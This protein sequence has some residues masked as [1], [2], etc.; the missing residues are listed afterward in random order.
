MA[1]VLV[2]LKLRLL[3]N[4]LRGSVI[5]K[6]G[7]ALGCLYALVLGAVAFTVLVTLRGRPGD[8]SVVAEVGGVALAVG[9]AG[10][11]LLGFGSDET[12]DPTR[13]ALLPIERRSL[14]T[15]LLGASMLGPV[16]AGTAIALAGA[17]V[18][19]APASAGAVLVVVAACLE[20]AMCVALSRTAVTTLSAALRSRKGRD[21]RIV[22][23]AFIGFMPEI[24]RLLL[25]NNLKVTNVG[26]L[27]PWAHALSWLPPVLPVRAMAAA[28]GGHW[29]AAVVELAG[30]V[31]TVGGLLAW[32]SRALDSVMTT[33]EAAPP[34]APSTPP[35]PGLEA[36]RGRVAMPLFDPGLDMLPRTRA[37]AVAARE[38]RYTWREPRRRVQMV[39]GILIPFVVLAGILS[40]GGLQE[41][42]IVFAGLLVAFL[43]GNNRAINQFGFDGQAFWIHEAAG[44]DL[45]ADLAGKNLALALTTFPVAVLTAVVLAAISGGWAELAMTVCLSAAI[46]GV[47]LGVGDVASILVPVPARDSP[48][49]LWGTQAGQGCTTGLLSLVV[50]V[51]EAALGAPLALGALLVHGIGPRV[52]VVVLGMGYGALLYTAGTAAAVRIGRDR[53]PELLAAISPSQ[54]G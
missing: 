41:H 22:V 6:F 53:G 18:A 5:R 2:R 11:P 14:M 32:W 31:A 16:P 42:R 54:T 51:I 36:R 38:L 35:A 26:V 37:G 30:A 1:W 25:L 8:L 13:L 45:G 24:A 12:L 46:I 50:L 4:G 23:V 49:N 15:G 3:V 20:L 28:S 10:L 17:V 39:S 7:F 47:L 27:R 34:R 19:F 9:W 40:K 29:A 21:L 48:G 52:A 33:A 43:A 44:H